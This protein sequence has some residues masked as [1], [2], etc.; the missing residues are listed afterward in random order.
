MGNILRRMVIAALGWEL[1]GY[2]FRDG[3]S[4]VTVLRWR[5]TFELLLV[6]LLVSEENI[7]TAVSG[8]DELPRVRPYLREKVFSHT[9]HW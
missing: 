7:A 8:E 4:P 2:A 3:A 5:L 1:G 6:A 9:K